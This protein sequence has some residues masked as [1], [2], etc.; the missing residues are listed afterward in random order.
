MVFYFVFLLQP[1]HFCPMKKLFT[2]TALLAAAALAFVSP[3]LAADLTV[4]PGGTYASI[5]AAIA[6]AADGDRILVKPKAIP[7]GET[8]TITKSLTI[9]CADEGDTFNCIGDWTFT[10]TSAQKKLVIIGMR[11]IAGDLRAGSAGPGVGRSMV[12]L[13]G[14]VL[15]G[16]VNFQTSNYD[17]LVAADSIY[18]AVYFNYG[19]V[20][21]NYIDGSNRNQAIFTTSEGVPASTDSIWVVGNKVRGGNSN[22]HSAIELTSGQHY[23]F[24]SN[25]YLTINQGTNKFNYGFY[26][27]GQRAASA[28]GGVNTMSN[29]TVND[30]GNQNFGS[31]RSA[32]Y[33]QG[34]L[35]NTVVAANLV[36]SNNAN[37]NGASVFTQSSGVNNYVFAYNIFR[38]YTFSVTVPGNGTN[39][40]TSTATI[41]LATGA[42]AGG[43]VNAGPTDPEYTDID[44]SRGD[45]GAFGGS[46]TLANFHPFVSATA[47]NNRGG[48]VYLLRAPRAIQQGG[49]IQVKA[50]GF[51]R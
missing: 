1:P 50:D 32:F 21:G 33:L 16:D 51:D 42:A 34:P 2:S 5:G 19:K 8:I 44:L 20:I 22:G 12:Q 30:Q 40:T 45:V 4:G 13:L 24:C 10:P 7:Y 26:M 18:G 41:N 38:G 23:I 39:L 31:G 49:S 46:F 11:N 47:A 36:V 35:N 28:A 9:A 15:R 6:A 27:N 48:R 37:G 29:N 14:S 3:A 17:V 25:N 43:A